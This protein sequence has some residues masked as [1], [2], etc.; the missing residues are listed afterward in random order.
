MGELIGIAGGS[1]LW[2]WLFSK[3]LR[4]LGIDAKGSVWWAYVMM[5]VAGVVIS[6][7]TGYGLT[8]LLGYAIFGFGWA[9]FLA[10]RTKPEPRPDAGRGTR[11][12]TE[13]EASENAEGSRPCAH[14]EHAN[15]FDA[16]FC[17]GCGRPLTT[18]VCNACA[19]ANQPNATFCK[20]CGKRLDAPPA[21]PTA[22]KSLPRQE[23]FAC[24]DCGERVKFG[25][26]HCAACGLEFKYVG[27]VAARAD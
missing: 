25:A 18:A 16:E 13:P 1:F 6:Q 27:G 23:P 14:C 19:T 26:S 17:V 15:D 9:V 8:G 10:H 7:A 2:Q 21:K 5:L 20:R 4:G 11:L 3:L 24:F 12:S 22:K